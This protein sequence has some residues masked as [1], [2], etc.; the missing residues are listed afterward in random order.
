MAAA[1]DYLEPLPAYEP[2]QSLA[3]TIGT[4]N[5]IFGA[6]LLCCGA[7]GALNFI[8]Q[9]VMAPMLQAQNDSMVQQM[10]A[11][12]EERIDR[13]R[14]EEK[15]AT[16]PEEK[17]KIRARRKAEEARPTPKVPDL[18]QFVRDKSLLTYGI[19]DSLVGIILNVALL[20]AGIGL[21]RLRNW[22]RV[23]SLWVAG[24]KIVCLTGL[25]AIF[26]I[27]VLPSVIEKLGQVFQDVGP[28]G[29]PPAVLKQ[30]T[31]VMTYA[32]SAGAVIGYIVGLIYPIVILVAL[33]RRSVIA[34]C[35]EPAVWEIEEPH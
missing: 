12:R 17:A 19:A 9:P 30:M 11:E 3:R 22:G 7:C 18:T 28:G 31:T 16:T 2:N 25:L 4:L 34:A 35:T 23:T 27:V 24:L 13:L 26:L 8:V 5:I 33:T 15:Q 29:P 6:I 21:V 1:D 14:L 32:Y 10:Q 20:I